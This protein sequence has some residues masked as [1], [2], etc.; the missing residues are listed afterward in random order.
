MVPRIRGIVNWGVHWDPAI[1][2][3]TIYRLWQ[4]ASAAIRA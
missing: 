2:E 4:G 1:L 3:A